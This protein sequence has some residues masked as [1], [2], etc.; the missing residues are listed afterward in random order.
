MLTGMLL[1]VLFYRPIF[2][3]LYQ[4]A[5]STNKKVVNEKRGNESSSALPA[6]PTSTYTIQ[7]FDDGGS[8]KTT[9]TLA[10]NSTA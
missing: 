1:G 9:S 6:T 7:Y 2:Q 10:N 5:D 4:T 8:M 3:Q